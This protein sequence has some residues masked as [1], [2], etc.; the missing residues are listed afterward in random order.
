MAKRFVVIPAYNEQH[1][2]GAVIDGILAAG[3]YEIVVVDDA[4]EFSLEKISRSKNC[5]YLRHRFNLGQGAALQTGI[6]F[7]LRCGASVIVSF[8]AD[9]QHDPADIAPIC[10]IIESGQA[11]IV[12]GS[13][14]LGTATGLTISRKLVIQ[15]ARLLH[16]LLTG[17]WM[18]DAHNGLRGL[19]AVAARKIRLRE[20]RMAHAT[21]IIIQ[22]KKLALKWKEVPVSVTY[23]DYSRAKGQSSSNGIRILFDVVLHKLFR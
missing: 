15:V 21:E 12:L 3:N 10:A 8:D 19:S 14:F 7:A 23:S 5:H 2:L 9:G 16:F 18:T 20:N 6:D 11:D 4:S 22:V 1:S 13:R 17:L